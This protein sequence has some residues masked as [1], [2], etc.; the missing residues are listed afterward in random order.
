MFIAEKWL[1]DSIRE[2]N[3]RKKN[4]NLGEK[5]EKI[6][7][8]KWMNW[9]LDTLLIFKNKFNVHEHSQIIL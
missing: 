2:E 5:L 9:W 4:Q 1:L 6:Q 3:E 8:K 7:N